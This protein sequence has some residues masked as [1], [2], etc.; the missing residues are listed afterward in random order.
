MISFKRVQCF[1][2]RPTNSWDRG[3]LFWWQIIQI[4]VRRSTRI[5]LVLDT[6][7]A[8][9]QQCSE[10]QVW[11][12]CWIRETGFNTLC[13]RV[14]R[15]RN[16]HSTRT[17]GRR[18]RTQNWRF[19]TWDQTFVRVCRWVCDRVQGRG[20]L[21]NTTD[22]VQCFLRQIGVFVACKDRL[23]VF[24]DRHVHVH[25]GAVIACDWLWHECRGFAVGLRDVVDY[26]FVFLDL[27][28]L[29]RQCAKN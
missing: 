15:P 26:I 5:D 11:V 12:G 14:F 16:T 8:S 7:K 9:H 23:A 2:Q 18:I 19:K 21:Q 29:M 10:A 22:E 27:V 20:V 1:A 24:P 13:L 25:A 6:V 28:G 17:V 4:F 3:Q